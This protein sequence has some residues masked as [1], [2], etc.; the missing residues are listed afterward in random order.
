MNRCR[1]SRYLF[2][3]AQP[4]E[5]PQ[6]AGA[7]DG[8]DSLIEGLNPEQRRAV[9]HGDG[10]LLVV[11]GAGTGKTQVIT[12]RIAW[13]IAT[14]RARPSR[15]WPS[16][17]RTKPRTRC[18]SESNQLVPYGYTDAA[19][20][21]FHAFGDRL[22][23]E[24][25]LELA[26]PP[27]CVCCRGR[28][29]VIFLRERLF[30]FELEEYRP[31]GDPTRFLGRLR[32][33]SADARTKDVSPGAYVDFAAE[34]QRSV[35]NARLVPELAVGFDA[36][37][38][39]A[40]AEDARRQTELARAYEQYQ[41][42]L[43]EAGLIDFGDQVSL[44]LR[45]ACASRRP[46]GW[47]FSAATAYILVDEFQDTNRAQ[48]ELVELLAAPHGKRNRRWPTDDQS[49]YKFR[50][51]AI[52]N[53][54]EFKRRHR[55]VRQIV[56]RRNYRSGAPLLECELPPHPIQRP[57]TAS[58]FATGSTSGS[59][60]NAGAPR[61]RFGILCSPRVPKRRTGVAREI[62]ARVAAGAAAAGLRRP[63]SGE[64]GCGSDSAEP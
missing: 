14:R 15:S 39:A 44:A 9:C 30:E 18:K 59:S 11:A 2:W 49:I 19:I 63:G 16:P 36:D 46:L 40:L 26:S 34:L 51:A 28:K 64:R 52:S 8:V 21:T 50:G 12:R 38:T 57:G 7:G 31:L 1:W 55:R 24:F 62:A 45:A 6:P 3:R 5:D 43:R 13:L 60:P 58:R 29:V 35:P 10:P 33:S 53:I 41:K 22:V 37:D 23:R 47:S 32:R 54:L 4:N 17:S 25:A 20:S 42:L 48:A 27:T 61:G 56:L